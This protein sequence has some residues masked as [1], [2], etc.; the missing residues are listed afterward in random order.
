MVTVSAQVMVVL[1]TKEIRHQSSRMEDSL[2]PV[3]ANQGLS[4][5]LVIPDS[6]GDSCHPPRSQ[7]TDL[8]ALIPS[9]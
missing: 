3:G 4:A 7:L 1:V 5:K 8:E 2:T 9:A 6:D